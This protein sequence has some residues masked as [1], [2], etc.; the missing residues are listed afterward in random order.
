MEAEFIALSEA[1]KELM[2]LKRIAEEC[3]D[4]GVSIGKPLIYCDSTA[5]IAYS[6]SN[7]ENAN[8]RHIEL[9]YH[10]VK[11]VVQNGH[12]E[13]RHVTSKDNIADLMTKPLPCTRFT[14][15][16]GELLSNME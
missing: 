10:Y 13:I 14:T 2:W 5:A 15:L 16:R 8:N 12:L 11:D 4:L 9:R 1:A 3:H 6:R 7:I